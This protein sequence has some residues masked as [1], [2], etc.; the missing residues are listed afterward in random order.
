MIWCMR[1]A[2]SEYKQV[3][4]GARNEEHTEMCSSKVRDNSAL[5]KIWYSCYLP[6]LF[7]NR[8]QVRQWSLT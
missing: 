2:C 7:S 6:I 5:L 4:D 8:R 1:T 3:D